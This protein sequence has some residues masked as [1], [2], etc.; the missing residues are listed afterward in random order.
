[1][2]LFV[3]ACNVTDIVLRTRMGLPWHPSTTVLVTACYYGAL[4]WFIV[5]LAFG[6]EF[7]AELA[8]AG[9]S[10]EKCQALYDFNLFCSKV[11]AGAFA[12]VCITQGWS[13]SQA[14][15]ELYGDAGVALAITRLSVLLIF[16]GSIG[17]LGWIGALLGGRVWKAAKALV[18][19]ET[20]VRGR[21]EQ[22]GE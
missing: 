8:K 21:D 12:V 5:R 2:G 15:K 19:A 9:K 10:R 1:M 22:P 7:D 16:V 20:S 3:A 4:F 17:L 13:L 6:T 18:D 14:H 11:V